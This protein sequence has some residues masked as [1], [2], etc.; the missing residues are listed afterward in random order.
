MHASGEQTGVTLIEV[1]V[2][3]VITS[4]GVLGLAGLQTRTQIAEMESYQRGQALLLLSDM[5]HRIQANRGAAVD[6]VTG[7]ANPL[8]AGGACP[9]VTNLSTQ[10]AIDQSQWC[11]SLQG[12]AELAGTS[13]I[14]AMIGGRGCVENIAPDE[15]LIT[16]AW[17]GLA[18]IAAPPA[19]VACGVT[20]YDSA[21]GGC[22][23][24]RC[25]RAVT[26]VVRIGSLAP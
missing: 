11:H 13:R 15:Y 16:V 5:A 22:S 10:E 23:D 18:P 17:Q 9:V 20:L 26:T 4:I 21:D 14:G 7:P 25:R 3:M 19:A 8:G 24:D 12:A 1:L 2:T 6:Y